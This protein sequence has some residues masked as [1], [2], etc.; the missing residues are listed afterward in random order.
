MPRATESI[1][2]LLLGQGIHEGKV[3]IQKRSSNKNLP[4]TYE[5]I[6][7]TCEP[8]D[9][10]LALKEYLIK[11]GFRKNK[12]PVIRGCREETGITPRDLEFISMEEPNPSTNYLRVAIFVGYT[13]ETPT[14][15]PDE[16]VPEESYFRTLEEVRALIPKHPALTL[17]QST[18]EKKLK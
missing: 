18:L 6:Q 8:S 14:P 1:I 5:P 17:V 10:P 4:G 11:Q 13:S 2:L 16:T 7:E 12:N 3:Y 9:Y 15:N